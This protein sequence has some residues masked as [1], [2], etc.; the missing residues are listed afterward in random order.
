[1]QYVKNSYI[2][3]RKLSFSKW[4]IIAFNLCKQRSSHVVGKEGL[5]KEKKGVSKTR[6]RGVFFV[7]KNAVLRLGLRLGLLKQRL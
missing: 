4:K 1:M 3:S 5:K 2:W 7:L 6:G